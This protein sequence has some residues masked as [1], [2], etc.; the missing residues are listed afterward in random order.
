MSD[1]YHTD[2][3][4]EKLHGEVSIYDKMGG[5]HISLTPEEAEFVHERIGELL[6]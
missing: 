6:N 1:G 3:R 5:G 2:L 4:V